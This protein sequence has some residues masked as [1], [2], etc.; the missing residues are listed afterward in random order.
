MA[1]EKG[2]DRE[3]E[4]TKEHWETEKACLEARK[5]EIE[6]DHYE[7]RLDLEQQKLESDLREWRVRTLIAIVTALATGFGFFLGKIYENSNE[8][9]KERF[10]ITLE[11]ERTEN[12]EFNKNL[13]LL[14]S[15]N[16]G[17]REAAVANLVWYVQESQRVLAAAN[18]SQI[19]R[20]QAAHRIEQVFSTVSVR[21]PS[22]TDT[23]VLEDYSMLLV[24]APQRALP[25]VVALNARAGA[26]LVRAG[27]AYIAWNINKP[28]EFLDGC[29]SK[30]KE[31]AEQLGKLAEL[32]VRT[33][34]PFEGETYEG[35]HIIPRF[36]VTQLLSGRLRTEYAFECR[37]VMALNASLKE[38]ERAQERSKNLEHLAQAARVMSV[39][40]ITLTETLGHLRG[41]LAGRDLNEIFVVTGNLDGL[42]LSGSKLQRSYINGWAKDFTCDGC[43]FSYADLSNL[44]LSPPCS[45]VKADFSGV[46]PEALRSMNA[47]LCKQ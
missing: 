34:M 6:V 37:R 30:R 5:L 29:D 12:E 8:D 19:S 27:A 17:E 23:A 40:S 36:S 4:K 35:K 10:Q 41:K 22:E 26:P 46:P 33:P 18:E 16:P 31:I 15:A 42:D 1:D 2:R 28:S 14:S 43:N 32:V 11:R 3:D 9:K 38:S 21:L 7:K 25:S 47:S 20:E 13:A 45:L 39:S 24:A 44:H